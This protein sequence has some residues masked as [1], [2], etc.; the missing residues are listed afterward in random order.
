MLDVLT[1]CKYSGKT[2]GAVHTV[3]AAASN[4]P[5]AESDHRVARSRCNHG[6][7]HMDAKVRTGAKLLHGLQKSL[8]LGSFCQNLKKIAIFIF[9]IKGSILA[10]ARNNSPRG[11]VSRFNQ[12]NFACTRMLSF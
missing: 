6:V 8:P 4:R 7:G 9:T 10:V 12:T 3:S 1:R 5:A 11:V 2:A